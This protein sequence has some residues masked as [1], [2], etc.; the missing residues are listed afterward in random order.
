MAT[1]QSPLNRPPTRRPPPPPEPEDTPEK[2][3]PMV[4]VVTAAVIAVLLLFGGIPQIFKWW[5][6]A[7]LESDVEEVY[8]I[9]A[10]ARSRAIKSGGDVLVVFDPAAR[11][12]TLY[13]DKNKNGTGE[14]G[15]VLTEQTLP[16]ALQ[17]APPEVLTDI[18]D[19][20]GGETLDQEAVVLNKGGHTL[21]FSNQGQASTDGA[22]Y[23]APNPAGDEP[24]DHLHA[25]Q[26]FNYGHLRIARY[27]PENTPPWK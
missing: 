14:P 17:F 1:R 10:Q 19:I 21:I 3:W 13:L 18:M 9:L 2:A 22:I 24:L 15:E 16:E 25:I 8:F 4:E 7:Q 11:A 6:A 5:D 12:Y 23:L 20:W 27:A 26:V